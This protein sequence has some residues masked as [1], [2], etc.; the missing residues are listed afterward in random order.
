MIKPSKKDIEE[1]IDYLPIL[2][3][4]EFNVG[5]LL[6]PPKTKSNIITGFPYYNYNG[7]V[8]DFFHL[9]SKECWRDDNYLSKNV[10][11]M[12]ADKEI[13]N[14]VSLTDIQSIL[15]FLVRGERFCDG[16]WYGAIKNETIKKVLTRLTELNSE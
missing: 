15:T 2:Y 14:N 1:L 5:K 8:N 6:Y 9:A 16:V 3:A 10:N 11:S 12:I 4:E 13:L 7:K